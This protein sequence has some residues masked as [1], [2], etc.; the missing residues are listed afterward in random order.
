MLSNEGRHSIIA[1][2]EDGLEIL[3]CCPICGSKERHLMYKR[4]T[5]RLY[6]APGQWTMYS[7]A[8]CMSGYLD[9]RPSEAT[10]GKAYEQYITH[11]P[12]AVVKISNTNAMKR[13]RLIIR[14]S[15]LNHK[16]GYHFEP[17][18]SWGHLV[19]YL[20]PPPLRWEWD[21]YARHLPT[22]QPGRDRLLDVGCGNGAFLAR[23]RQLGWKVQGLEFDL[24]AAAVAKAQ[25]ID[26][27][28]GDYHHAPFPVEFFD[29]ITCHQVI[30]HVHDINSFIVF[31]ASLLKPEGR[32]W[33]GTPNFASISRKLFGP[34]WRHLHPPQHLHI[35]SAQALL[36]TLRSHGLK[37][38]LLPRGYFEIHTAIESRA[39]HD[40]A[41][42]YDEIISSMKKIKKHSLVTVA[43]ETASWL[44][45]PSGC[46]L[47]VLGKK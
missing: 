11:E 24:Q 40:G 38:Q 44:Y 1:W 41:V 12:E 29:T 25:G 30:E 6:G 10:I 27:W 17:S 26:V 16:Y 39:L 9:P 43:M 8:H 7:C 2:P 18:A 15:Y 13:L 4:L 28:V 19:M 42:G 5:D 33:L 20:L 21:H 37:V 47:V 35:F 14:N 46:D 36:S 31:L 3:G 34:D 23:A 22:P 45:P 32:I